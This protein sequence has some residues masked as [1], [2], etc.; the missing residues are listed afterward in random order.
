[1]PRFIGNN[2]NDWVILDNKRSFNAQGL[3]PNTN[4][5]VAEA[6]QLEQTFYQM[7]LN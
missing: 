2:G 6:K 1:M 4:G 3:Y 5:A 7:V